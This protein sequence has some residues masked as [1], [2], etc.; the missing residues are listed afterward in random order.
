MPVG[1]QATVKALSQ[2]ELTDFDARILLGNTYHLF[3]RPGSSLI[4]DAGGLHGFMGWNGSIL[5]DS[6]GYQVFSLNDLRKIT[7]EGVTFRSH[8]DGSTHLFTPERVME[9]E[10]DLG[11]DIIMAFDEC[12]PYPSTREYTIRSCTMTETWAERCLE[13]YGQLNDGSQV[14]FGICQGGVYPEI[15]E[16]Y[17]R[18]LVDLDFWGYA[19][20]GLAVGE[21]KGKMFEMVDVSTAVLPEKKPRYLMGVGF[22]DDMVEAVSR[23]IDMFDCVMPTRNAR[24]GTVFTREGKI[25]L[26]NASQAREFSPID[27][28]CG[29]PACRNYTKAYI[30]HLF[31]AGEILAPRLATMHSIYFYLQIMREMRAAILEDRFPEWRDE[32]FTSYRNEDDTHEF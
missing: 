32:F 25:V 17:A 10:H 3:L 18:R 31:Q 19:V 8:I 30:R 12:I 13:A 21:P 23:G 1:T 9:I 16:E 29:C 20:G 6:G 14:L 5:T 11:A 28:E 7:R 27:P 22:P 26:K 15:R 24:N 2:Q 4:R